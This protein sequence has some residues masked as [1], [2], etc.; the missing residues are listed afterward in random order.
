VASPVQVAAAALPFMFSG[1]RQ[2]AAVRVG[3]GGEGPDDILAA[4]ELCGVEQVFALGVGDASECLAGALEDADCA[5]LLLGCGKLGL[6]RPE[7][8]RAFVW[9]KPEAGRFAV[10]SDP[11]GCFDYE[12]MAWAHPHARFTVFGDEQADLPD[13]FSCE[14]GGFEAM[15]ATRPEAV[16]AC[17]ALPE[18]S[19]L[20]LPLVLG[21]G[22]EGCFFWPDLL[23]RRIAKTSLF[24]LDEAEP[25]SEDGDLLL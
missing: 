12:V 9:E 1:V 17:T 23:D 11:D 16:F 13:N 6:Q 8:V 3:P 22:Q 21:P 15:I 7:S 24:V 10:L 25:G 5:C 14:E 18:D 2:V 19:L 20:Q 4:L